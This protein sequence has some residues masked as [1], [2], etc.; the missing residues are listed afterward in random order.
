MKLKIIVVV[1]NY[2]LLVLLFILQTSGYSLEIKVNYVKK[3]ILIFICHFVWANEVFMNFSV[4]L[5]SY[6]HLL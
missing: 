6:G 1:Q 3:R 4:S 2:R 5:N